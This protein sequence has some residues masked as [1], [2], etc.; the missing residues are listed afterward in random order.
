MRRVLQFLRFAIAITFALAVAHAA[1]AQADDPKEDTPR[2]DV[3]GGYSY[4]RSNIVVSDTS[5]NLN[6]ASGSIS[7]N[8]NGWLGVVGD[9]G[10]YHQGSITANGLSL[11]VSTYQAGPRFSLRRHPR[12]TPFGQVL[13]GAGHAGGTLYTT[14]LGGGVPPLGASNALVLTAGAGVDW[15]VTRSVGIRVIQAEYLYSQFNNGAGHGS[16]QNN[17][18]LSA[19]IVFSFGKR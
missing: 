10:V 5:I 13:L 15:K 14:S 2:V 3:F 11:T 6:G 17:V 4:M 12:L 9:V 7:Y 8:F 18:R 1:F 16:E 19:G